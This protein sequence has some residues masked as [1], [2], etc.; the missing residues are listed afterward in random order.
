MAH[1]SLG[2]CLLLVCVQRH[3]I[4]EGARTR[5]G[6][7]TPTSKSSWMGSMTRSEWPKDRCYEELAVDVQENVGLLVGYY[8]GVVSHGVMS[9]ELLVMSY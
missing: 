2:L 1:L 9:T 4:S 3:V 5:V 8:L 6:A 7:R